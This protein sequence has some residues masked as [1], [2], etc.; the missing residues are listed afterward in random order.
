MAPLHIGLWYQ[1]GFFIGAIII[2][3]IVKTT[4]EVMISLVFK[5]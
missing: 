1:V 5:R 3:F 4:I 2:P